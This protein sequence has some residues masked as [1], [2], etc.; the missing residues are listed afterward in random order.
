MKPN[1]LLFVISA[2]LI[3]LQI[4]PATAIAADQLPEWNFGIGIEQYRWK[5]TI[6]GVAIT[7]KENGSRLALFLDWSPPEKSGKYFSYHGKI[8]TGTVPYDTAS[9][10]TLTPVTT[11][12]DYFGMLNEVRGVFPTNVLDVVV[13]LGYDFWSRTI[14]DGATATGTVVP[15]YTENWGILFARFGMSANLTES[16]NIAAGL[17]RTIT[18]REEVNTMGITGVGHPGTSTSPYLDLAYKFD[19]GFSLGAYYDSWRFGKSPMHSSTVYQP[20]SNMDLFGIK[21]IWAM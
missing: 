16:F 8:Y 21:A 6:E 12:T 13:G 4:I 9:L 7:P 11:T 10:T 1:S 20:K 5:E 17:K 15:G 19:D 14:S 18:N 3:F 2:S